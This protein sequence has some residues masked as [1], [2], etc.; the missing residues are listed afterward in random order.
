MCYSV[1]YLTHKNEVY[2]RRLGVTSDSQPTFFN[3]LDQTKT[4]LG[5]G[6]FKYGFDHPG[7]P[8]LI[9]NI[10]P[11]SIIPAFWGLIPKWAR[12]IEQQKKIINN[13]L[14]AR[15]ETLSEKPSFRN[16]INNR[17]IVLLDGFFEYQQLN[18]IKQPHFIRHSD[19]RPMLVAGIF[20]N[21]PETLPYALSVS[22]LTRQA[23]TFMQSIHNTVE[24]RMPVIMEAED[25]D[26]WLHEDFKAAVNHL[27]ALPVDDLY[28]IPVS[29]LLGK[30]GVGNTPE[31]QM[32]L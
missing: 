5:V 11:F 25:I 17:C 14:N 27:D 3:Q 9:K 12:T 8:V 23:N 28:A 13:T 16:S 22:I 21:A 29:K 4:S 15:I 30:E 19:H 10:S 6:W 31:A 18:K 2:A 1:S 24:P 7:L 32:P 26:I 20:E